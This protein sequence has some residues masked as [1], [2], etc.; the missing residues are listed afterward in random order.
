MSFEECQ[1]GKDFYAL[2]SVIHS[3]VFSKSKKLTMLV[4]LANLLQSVDF[5]KFWKVVEDNKELNLNAVTGF[6]DRIRK[7]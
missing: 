6:N 1:G 7:V 5:E 2:R 4:D 3:V